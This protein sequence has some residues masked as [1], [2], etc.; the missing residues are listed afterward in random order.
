MSTRF[1]I[2]SKE[3]QIQDIVKQDALDRYEKIRNDLE[4]KISKN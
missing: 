3:K 1:E 2:K 4:D